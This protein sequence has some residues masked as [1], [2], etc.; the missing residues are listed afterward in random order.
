MKTLCGLWL[1]L[2]LVS[3]CTAEEEQSYVQLNQS[4]ESVL[5]EVGIVEL[6][7]ARELELVHED[8][9]EVMGWA[10]VEPGGGPVETEHELTVQV[11]S[12]YWHD[13]DRVSART[14]SDELGEDEYDLDPR[15]ADEGAWSVTLV[16]VGG[17]SETRSDTIT[18]RLWE[19]EDME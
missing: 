11:D 14:D 18:F 1:P 17:E 12:S 5:I 9:G 7:E 13:V 10:Q 3:A 8:D 15:A 4:D 6:L 19:A 2:V 16:S